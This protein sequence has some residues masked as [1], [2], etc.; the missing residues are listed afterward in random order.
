MYEF[1]EY[2]V[3]DAMTYRPLTVSLDTPLAEIEALF[4]RHDFNSLP[5]VSRDGI[6]VGLVTK[7]DFLKAFAFTPREIV[8]HYTE[9]MCRPAESVVTRNPITVRPDMALTRLL[10]LMVETRYRS[11]PVAIGALLIGIVARQDVLRALRR[12]AAGEEP[13]LRRA[14]PIRDPGRA[15]AAPGRSQVTGAV[16]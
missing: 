1:L 16:A 11:F 3:A 12:A 8:P 14:D 13:K 6:L 15:A 2:Q 9:I 7:L 4:E 10:Q 5:V